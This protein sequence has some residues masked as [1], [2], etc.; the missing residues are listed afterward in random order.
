MRY[1]VLGVLIATGRIL[2]IL[3]CLVFVYAAFISFGVGQS[4][5]SLGAAVI[6]VVG[7]CAIASSGEIVRVLIDIEAN[8]RKSVEIPEKTIAEEDD[9]L[10]DKQ[11]VATSNREF[12]RRKANANTSEQED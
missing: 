2:A 5:Y 11:L 9:T 3:W 7:G 12:W 8:T 4:I 1:P 10:E 6:G